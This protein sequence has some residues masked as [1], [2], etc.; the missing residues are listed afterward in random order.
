MTTYIT[1]RA[2]IAWRKPGRIPM[3]RIRQG[4]QFNLVASQ[5]GYL[6]FE[7]AN[8]KGK[9]IWWWISALS[10]N[11]VTGEL[12]PPPV[13]MGAHRRLKSHKMIPE[14]AQNYT[15]FGIVPWS[16]TPAFHKPHSVILSDALVS[17]Y[18]DLQSQK[19]YD[20][21]IQ[22]YPCD[23]TSIINGPGKH[24]NQSESFQWLF[25]HPDTKNYGAELI[26]GQYSIPAQGGFGYNMIGVG[27]Q[28]GNSTEVI[29]VTAAK[30]PTVEQLYNR[31]DLVHLAWGVGKDG[32]TIN[33]PCGC[34]FVLVLNPVGLRGVT[35]ALNQQTEIWVRNCWLWM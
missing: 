25:K 12:P 32:R 4:F 9:T 27:K 5:P 26:D 30:L 15:S 10:A 11:K 18:W 20:A 24:I 7:T 17:L 23:N 14:E 16:A 29:G 13:D 1:N 6:A 2:T 33:P 3:G 34:A 21:N 28:I 31:P 8:S 19:Y 35:N 22:N